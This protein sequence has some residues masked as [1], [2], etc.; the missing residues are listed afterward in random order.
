MPEKKT[1]KTKNIKKS[2]K[3]K[4]YY[5]EFSMAGLFL[6][7]LAILLILGWIFVLGIFVGRDMLPDGIQSITGYTKI[8]PK[9]ERPPAKKSPVSVPKDSNP[10]SLSY[11]KQLVEKKEAVIKNRINGARHQP[12]PKHVKTVKKAKTSIEHKTLPSQ[13]VKEAR[14]ATLNKKN[15]KKISKKTVRSTEKAGKPLRSGTKSKGRYTIQL[16]SVINRLEA[17]KFTNR[18]VSKGYPAFY[19]KAV[20]RGRTYYRVRCGRFLNR[21]QAK[22]FRSRL[23]KKEGISGFI[24]TVGN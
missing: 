18:L 11:H 24:T 10:I 4:K 16:T 22:K 15:K 12:S 1:K 3:P 9:V 7:G 20:I 5:I 8:S 17:I 14:T 6:W 13:Q 2:K 21:A 23:M 19:T